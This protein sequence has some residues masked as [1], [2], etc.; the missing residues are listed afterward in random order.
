NSTLLLATV[1]AL[2]LLSSCREEP[3]IS[4]TIAK[5]DL[6]DASA[7]DGTPSS[8]SPIWNLKWQVPTSWKTEAPP[9]AAR[10]RPAEE[11]Q[12]TV[13]RLA[14]K[15]GGILA[16]VN[17]WRGQGGLKP[18][19]G[20]S[21][22]EPTVEVT[23]GDR[24]LSV[25]EIHA[26]ENTPGI[27][28]I[29]AG[30][31]PLE[32]ETWFFKFTAADA[33]LKKHRSE[34][35][36][37]LRSLEIAQEPQT[38][39][40]PILP[41]S[42]TPRPPEL[43]YSSPGEWQRS[44]GSAMRVASFSVAGS[45]QGEADVAIVPLPGDA[46]S[47]LENANWWRKQLRLEPLEAGAEEEAGQVLKGKMGEFFLMHL[48][49]SEPLLENGSK[50]AISAAMIKQGGYTWFFKMTGDAETVLENRDRF[51]AFVRSA[52]IP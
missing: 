12:V 37:F 40:A 1:F 15:G 10:Y 7:P 25:F 8:A 26:P 51:E 27:N 52:E 48:Q 34:F 29:L 39:N 50:A 17:R 18:L 43:I 24:L 28:S 16:N 38:S 5:E 32:G 13:T 41:Q 4:Y 31:L 36:A 20:E 33:I 11:A 47:T 21:P 22:P 23:L 42:E 14:G 30:I 2:L 6:P 9:P 45:G 46:G 3:V 19:T 35:L 44:E 49:S